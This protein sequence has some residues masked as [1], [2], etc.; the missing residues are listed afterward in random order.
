MLMSIQST[1]ICLQLRATITDG[2]FIRVFV[3]AVDVM[4]N[5]ATDSLVVGVDSSPPRFVEYTF[6]KNVES[7][8][9]LLSYSSRCVTSC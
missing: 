6:Q 9:P 7:G 8:R 2:H 3:K 1:C 4:G 5:N